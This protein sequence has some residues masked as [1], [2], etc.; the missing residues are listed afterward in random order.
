MNKI[1]AIQLNS[2]QHITENLATVSQLMQAAANEGANVV[3]LP[4]M[5]ALMG[6]DNDSKLAAAETFGHGVMQDFLAQHSQK[7]GIW[8][9]GGT[10]P[11][12]AENSNKY[13]AACLVFN[14]QGE[15]VGRYNKMH[16]FDACLIENEETYQESSTTEPGSDVVVVETPIG[17][18]GLA[19]CYDLRF[20]ELFRCLADR[21]AEIIALPAAFA[22]TTGQVHW[23]PLMRSRAIE[24]IYYV[25]GACQVGPHGSGRK[26]YGHSIIIDPWG[27]I[28]SC[29]HNETPGFIISE[30]DLAHLQAVRKKIPVHLHRRIKNIE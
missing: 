10:I 30:I 15:V 27:E 3:I 2:N 12:R 24:N 18:I 6:T 20:P 23:E 28:K 29:M 21:G 22:L 17:K 8:I 11:I 26:T 19:V 16:L 7:L 9:I 5:F 13:Y 14:N 4:E 1:A 25:V